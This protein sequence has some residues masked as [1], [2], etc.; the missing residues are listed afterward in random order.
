MLDLECATLSELA[1]AASG[2][3]EDILAV[4][5]GYHYLGMTKNSINLVASA[6]A[7][8]HKVGVRTR[9]QA[10]ELVL[11]LLGLKTRC[12]KVAVHRVW[13]IYEIFILDALIPS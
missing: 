1:L 8:I 6:T 3:A 12:E 2:L 11:V 13:G 10:F 5:A 7:H 4:V 9:S